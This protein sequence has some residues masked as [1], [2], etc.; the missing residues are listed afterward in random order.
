VNI[1]KV[2][3]G[4]KMGVIIPICKPNDGSWVEAEVKASEVFCNT[5]RSPFVSWKNKN[6]LS[7]VHASAL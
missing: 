1:I 2:K 4:L 7:D 5:G 6:N 3:C